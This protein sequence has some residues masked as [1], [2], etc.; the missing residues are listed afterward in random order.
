MGAGATGVLAHIGGLPVEE[1]APFVVP[2]LALFIYVRRKDRDRR[3]AVAELPS[4]SAALDARTVESVV[5]AWAAA[6]YRDVGAEELPLLYPPG[7]DGMSVG[8]IAAR[9]GTPAAA[10]ERLLARLEE[11]EYLDLRAGEDANEM[12]ALLTLKGYGLVHATEDALVSAIAAAGAPRPGE[13]PRLDSNQQP[14]A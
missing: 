7:P 8:E 4:S 10:V 12:Q 6:G 5:E 11:H 1:W 3:R 2:A 13:R 14:P 9:T